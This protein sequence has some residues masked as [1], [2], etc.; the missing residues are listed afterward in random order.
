MPVEWSAAPSK[1]IM[2]MTATGAAS[3]VFSYKKIFF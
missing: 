3:F 2:G 1:L